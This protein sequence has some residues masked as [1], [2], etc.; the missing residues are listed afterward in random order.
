MDLYEYDLFYEK[1]SSALHKFRQ[2][3]ADALGASLNCVRNDKL[4]ML[5]KI[6]NRLCNL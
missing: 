6:I 3:I 4:V 1:D 5:H 2:P